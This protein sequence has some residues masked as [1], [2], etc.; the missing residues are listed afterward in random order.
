LGCYSRDDAAIAEALVAM[1]HVLAQGNEQAADSHQDHGKAEERRL[2]RFMRNNPPT[3]KGRFNP[4]GAQTWIQGVERIIRAM[5]TS[6]DQ[7][8]RLVS[9]MLVDEAEYW[10]TG[11]KRR[12]EASGEVVSWERFK[13][14][15]LRKYFLE[16]ETR[17]RWSSCS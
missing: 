5:V 2:D 13:S 4:D 12:L 7:K 10:W 14:D 9:H 16:E 17:K 11:A 6:D 1:A 8:V 15:F 3:F